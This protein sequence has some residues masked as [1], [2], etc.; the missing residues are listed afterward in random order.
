MKKQ[1]EYPV[2]RFG[3]IRHAETVW[4]RDKKIQGHSDSPLTPSGRLHAE[5]W[6]EQLRAGAWDR[7]LVS[8]LGRTRETAEC[9]NRALG[10]C[11]DTDSGLCEQSWGLWEGEHIPS[12]QHEEELKEQVAAG[13]GFCPPE[14]ED[15]ESV[16]KRGHAA[17]CRA[18]ERWPGNSILV[19]THEG[20]LKCLIYRLL[21][22]KF[23][24]SEPGVIVS[25]YLHFLRHDSKGL[26][27]DRINAEALL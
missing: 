4:N 27:M 14:G 21:G 1:N 2:T 11:I 23:L 3:L 22:R 8:D 18:A 9:I 15:R 20:V 12:L 19:V 5:R 13:W 6:G 24:P 10:L 17:L 16:W 25:G 7:M 26:S